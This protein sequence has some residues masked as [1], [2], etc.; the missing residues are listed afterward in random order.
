VVDFFED[1]QIGVV[2]G[3]SLVVVGV[4]IDEFYG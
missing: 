2:A 4:I 3:W 1:V